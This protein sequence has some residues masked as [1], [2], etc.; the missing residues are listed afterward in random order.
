MFLYISV[1]M[2]ESLFLVCDFFLILCVD[3]FDGCS[4]FKHCHI[5]PSSFYLKSFVCAYLHGTCK[6]VKFIPWWFCQNCVHYYII[7][8][9]NH[10]DKLYMLLHGSGLEIWIWDLVWRSF[11]WPVIDV[12]SVKIGGRSQFFTST[13]KR[14]LDQ[15]FLLYSCSDLKFWSFPF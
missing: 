14:S 8:I 5:I 10:A 3:F 13:G 4:F 6:G 11:K 15:M 7:H 9:Q 1:L 2:C 12:K